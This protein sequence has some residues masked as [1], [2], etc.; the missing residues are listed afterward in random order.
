[1]IE[2]KVKRLDV[3]PLVRHYITELDLYKLFQNTPEILSEFQIVN[4]IEI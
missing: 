4:K 2:S 3:L 1:M